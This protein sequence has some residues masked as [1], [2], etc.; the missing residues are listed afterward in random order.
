MQLRVTV[1]KS[2]KYHLLYEMA[3]NFVYFF[4]SP[5]NCFNKDICLL[6]CHPTLVQLVPRVG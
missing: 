1:L 5:E 4:I 3:L 6:Q 2:Q